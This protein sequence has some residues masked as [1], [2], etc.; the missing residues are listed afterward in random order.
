[1]L[2]QSS[3]Q[4]RTS[5]GLIHENTTRV[6]ERTGRGST[7]LAQ[8]S[9][10]LTNPNVLALGSG[11]I[12]RSYYQPVP[13]DTIDT[14]GQVLLF[15]PVGSSKRIMDLVTTNINHVHKE[16]AKADIFFVHYDLQQ[17]AWLTKDSDWYHKHIAF[18]VSQKGYKFQLTR[19]LIF[20]KDSVVSADSYNWIWTLDEDI[21]FHA[22]NL[23]RMFAI[24]D[25]SG[26]LITIPAFT[27]AQDAN[28][29]DSTLDYPIQ[30]PRKQCQYRYTPFVEVMFPLIRPI[31]LRMI[32]E[33][34]ENCIH[35]HSFWG[36]DCV[37]CA[38]SAK[39]MGSPNKTA[40]AII[41]ETP[42]LHMNYKTMG[43]KYGGTGGAE[44]R[45]FLDMALKDRDDVKAHHPDEF[46]D[47]KTD[48]WEHC[49][50]SEA[51]RHQEEDAVAIDGLSETLSSLWR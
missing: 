18:S 19:S 7:A 25:L 13:E 30:E 44:N 4:L 43:T 51:E 46:V 48:S 42:A 26:A 49:V 11:F 3:V 34:C 32:T 39:Q 38:W 21:D 47:M 17:A 31:V 5:K 12:N 10:N 1:M 2:L 33:E 36:L 22:M 40:C 15:W 41:D 20:G 14:S 16:L 45:T 27:Q 28:K 23:P 6:D 29:R 24:A 35:D 50:K 8:Q 9:S 37:W